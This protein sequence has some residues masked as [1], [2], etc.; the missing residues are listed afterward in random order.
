MGRARRA[1]GAEPWH[2]QLSLVLLVS[3]LLAYAVRGATSRDFLISILVTIG[4]FV[5]YGVVIFCALVAR[6]ENAFWEWFARHTT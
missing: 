3:M 1:F 2:Y 5:L 6:A 4:W